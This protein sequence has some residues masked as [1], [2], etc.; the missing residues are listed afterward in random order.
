MVPAPASAPV[1]GC[2]APITTSSTSP[3][4]PP[5]VS[6][7]PHAARQHRGGHGHRGQAG[8]LLHRAGSLPSVPRRHVVG[9]SERN[10]CRTALFRSAVASARW[11]GADL[12]EYRTRTPEVPRGCCRTLTFDRVP[13]SGTHGEGRGYERI[14]EQPRE[15]PGGRSRR[16]ASPTCSCSSR[17]PT[18]PLGVSEIARTLGL[19]KAVVHRILQSLTSRSL[20]AA[21]PGE[22]TYILGP[23]RHE[24]SMRAWSQLDL[25][26]RGRAGPAQ[27]ARRDPGDDHALGARRP[28]A[29][30]P[31]PVRE[32]A[33]GQDGHR[34]RPPLPAALRRLEPG[35]PRPP[36]REPFIDETCASCA[37]SIPTSTSTP[38]STTSAPYASRAMPPPQRARHRG[39]VHRVAVLRPAGNVL[40]RSAPRDRSSATARRATRTTPALVMSA[41]RA[42]S[43]T[44]SEHGGDPVNAPPRH[45]A[46][47]LLPVRARRASRS[48][49]P[50]RRP[51]RPTP[52]SSTSR[53]PCPL[54]EQG[55]GHATTCAGGSRAATPTA[56]GPGAQRWVRV[57]RRRPCRRPRG[58]RRRP[59][60]AG[61]LLAKRSLAGRAR[62]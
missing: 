7:S 20:A 37:S 27:A 44:I 38:T 26:Y 53:T 33:G 9:S 57:E 56:P 17:S 19:S 45:R 47:P 13:L 46:A 36:A 21:V 49:S 2:T 28:P 18:G 34:A 23:G 62:S 6:P 8:Q 1:S 35:H 31:R 32:P 30:L 41:A 22:S 29:D 50:R 55:A 54:A 61:I 43:A 60:L 48:S 3:P 16:T 52:S 59:G 42:I 12:G 11:P 51:A 14:R 4:E 25:R 40:A 5:P 24:L 15:T 10:G 39:R 58:R